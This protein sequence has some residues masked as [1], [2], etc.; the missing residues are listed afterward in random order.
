MTKYI[1]N[2]NLIKLLDALKSDYEVF[3]PV[4]KNDRRFYKKY[5]QF[6]D[7]IVIGEVRPSEPLKAFFSRAREVVAEGFETDIPHSGDRPFAIV[8]VDRKSVV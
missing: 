1:S 6:S 2:D 8:G 5:T 3:V 7:D 4:K